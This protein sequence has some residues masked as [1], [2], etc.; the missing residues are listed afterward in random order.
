MPFGDGT[1]RLGRGRNC[2]A[3][4]VSDRAGGGFGRGRGFG[5]GFARGAGY[6]FRRYAEPTKAEEKAQL[7]AEL[8]SAEADIAEI[9]KR[10]QELK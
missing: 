5:R 10:L 2:D 9:K 8:K 6:G 3:V 4:A 1:G 7:E